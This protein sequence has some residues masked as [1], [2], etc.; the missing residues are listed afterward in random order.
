MVE[1]KTTRIRKLV[2]STAENIYEIG[3]ELLQVKTVLGHGAFLPWLQEHFNEWSL[4]TAERFMSV[5]LRLSKAAENRQIGKFAPSALY[6]LAAAQT[7]E[8]ARIEAVKQAAAGKQITYTGAKEIVEKAKAADYALSRLSGEHQDEIR[9]TVLDRELL[10][11]LDRHWSAL[12]G[13]LEG[14]KR[15]MK[16]TG[17]LDGLAEKCRKAV[18]S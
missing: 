15:L 10:D 2:E 4:S 1:R 7:P 13:I 5:S 17:A 11:R 8:P 14:D 9:K 18:G 12:R 3:K 16:F 6:L